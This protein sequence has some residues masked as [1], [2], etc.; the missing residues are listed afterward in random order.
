M[1]CPGYPESAIFSYVSLENAL[2]CLHAR[3]GSPPTRGTRLG[4][5]AFYHVN[6]SCRVRAILANRREISRENMATRG[7]LFRSYH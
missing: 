7:D 5:L 2:K 6:G 1:H 3:Q 4:G